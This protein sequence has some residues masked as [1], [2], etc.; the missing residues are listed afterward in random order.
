[1]EGVRP[2]FG[3]QFKVLSFMMGKAGH[4]ELEASGP[5]MRKWRW[6]NIHCCLAG[7]FLFLFYTVEIPT[8]E[9]S[10]PWLRRVFLP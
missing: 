1:M 10:C 6:K 8:R 7:Q 2:Y 3:S 5:R 9:W 4:L